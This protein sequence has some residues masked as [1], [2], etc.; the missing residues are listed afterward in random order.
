MPLRPP[1]AAGVGR[2]TVSSDAGTR[3]GFEPLLSRLI[4]L[5][6][7]AKAAALSMHIT[8]SGDRRVLYLPR[9]PDR[10]SASRTCTSSARSVYASAASLT[11]GCTAVM[12][13]QVSLRRVATD[14]PIDIDDEFLDIQGNTIYCS[15]CHHRYGEDT[16]V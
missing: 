7:A 15:R 9:L 14:H 12:C 1:S 8:I 3:V 6:S 16:T 4:A 13:S 5:V 11:L 2:V 10:L